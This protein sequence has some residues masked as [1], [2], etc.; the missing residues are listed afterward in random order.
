MKMIQI[1]EEIKLKAQTLGIWDTNFTDRL[2]VTCKRKQESMIIA[3]SAEVDTWGE[4]PSD[5]NLILRDKHEA[6]MPYYPLPNAG[7]YHDKP[8]D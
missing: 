5:I 1:L 7:S 6:R 3:P 2:E 8:E 4:I